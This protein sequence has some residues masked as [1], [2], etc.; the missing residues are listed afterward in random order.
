[1]KFSRT[2]IRS[3]GAF[4]LA[5]LVGTSLAAHSAPVNAAAD[6][7]I[8]TIKPGLDLTNL[9]T[10]CKACDDFYQFATGG[11]QKKNPIPPAYASWGNFN[12]LAEQNREVL[13][14]ILEDA[15]KD[16]NA[17]PGSN[18]QKI[19]S[20]Y[21][22]CMDTDKIEAAGIDPIK[23]E[24]AKINAVT[25]TK[26][27]MLEIARLQAQGLDAGLQFGSTADT[28]DSSKTIAGVG[29]GGL[30]MPDRDYYLK[31]DDR[32]KTIRA[33]YATYV[34]T[35][36]TN[37]GDDATTAAKEAAD[38]IA[39][40]TALAKATPTRIELRDPSLT[41]HPTPVDQLSTL[42]P[43]VPWS[44]IFAV[45][46]APK[47]TT[48]DIALPN[49]VKAYNTELTATPL[50]TWKD[51]L[52]FHLISSLANALPKRFGDASFAFYSTTLSGVKVQQ[53]RWKRCVSATD[54]ALGEALGAV[55][56]AKV[57]P[58]AAKARA[59]SLVDNLQSVLNADI[60]QLPWMSPETRI[61]ASEKLEAYTKKIGYPDTF[62]NYSKLIIG[63][64]YVANIAAVSAFD[65]AR[66]VAKI[67]KPTDR[68]E[69]GMT[70]PTV[71]AYYNPSNNEIVFPAGILRPPFFSPLADDAVNY[72]AIGAVIGHEMT[73]G[74]DD[75][76]RQFDAKGNLSDWWT[77]TDAEK[78]AK[79]AN[80]IVTQFDGYQVAPGV[81]EQGQLVQGE[82]IADL[83]GI[84]I[85][86]KAFQ[87]TAEY[88]AHKK[89][90]G[91]TPE[92]RFFLAYAQV[93]ASERTDAY[94]RQAAVVDPHPDPKWR[95]IGTLSNMPE[96][97]AAFHCMA[98][99]KMVRANA[100]QIW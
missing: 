46:G 16:T 41:Y 81:H 89:I 56:V 6:L 19:G 14:T 48:V 69:W 49:Y 39:L 75:E 100:C 78:F 91:Y 65:T 57:F 88:K 93:W 22:S 66:D 99:D 74:F 60:K 38:V 73:H 31:D 44:D 26:S 17:T 5:A 72:G 37:A 3:L 84:T 33:A 52:R 47:F 9:D 61:K 90:D 42:A 21:R 18:E 87:K 50:S 12:I 15:A 79:R 92:Q 58:P 95:V 53:P 28:K 43:N 54:G 13:H 63:D 20:Y 68:K 4:A 80:C 2:L 76:G 11:W 32:S 7:T 77:K 94:Q 35:Q 82:A 34:T 24:L 45:Y 30:G 29:F 85:A 62:I 51:Y 27:L 8:P 67:G 10:S 70:P 83:G 64:S 96:F 55:Y 1:M 97:K 98:G 25:D 23:D 36:F 59:L 40:E 86:Y 71:N